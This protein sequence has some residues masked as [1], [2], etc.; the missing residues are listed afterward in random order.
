MSA[1]SKRDLAALRSAG[2][3]AAGFTFD[4]MLA[5]YCLEPGVVAHDLEAGEWVLQA[6]FYPPL[7]SGLLEPAALHALIAGCIAG[8]PFPPGSLSLPG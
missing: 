5:S 2:I 7:Q 4:T 6:P 3:D 1:D 8:P